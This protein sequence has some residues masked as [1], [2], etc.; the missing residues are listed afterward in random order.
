MHTKDKGAIAEA[1]VIADLT[2]QGHKVALP[3]GENLPFDLIAIRPNYS[4][5]RLQVK[6]RSA[7]SRGAVDIKLAS[8]WRN[9]SITRVIDYDLTSLDCFAI[10]CPELDRVA[11]VPVGEIITNKNFSL[12]IKPA[13]NGQ[14]KHVRLFDEYS[15]LE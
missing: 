13:K 14:R 3:L 1:C 12:R 8:T 5:V 15:A 7:S 6:Y 2:K 9:S 11:Y 10:Y 4:L